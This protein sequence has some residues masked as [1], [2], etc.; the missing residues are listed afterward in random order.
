MGLLD[1]GIRG[2]VASAVNFVMLDGTLRKWS[3]G[4]F[5]QSTQKLTARTATDYGVRGFI[6]EDLS[7]YT[8]EALV[9]EAEA[10]AGIVQV[11]AQASPQVGDHFVLRSQVWRIVKILEDPAEA[12][13][14]CQVVGAGDEQ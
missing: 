4:T 6:D 5:N 10:I 9:A 3:A 14:F 13:W 2:I 8:K 11:G 7:G 1:G 12:M